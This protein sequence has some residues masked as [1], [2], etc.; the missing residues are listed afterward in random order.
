MGKE[1]LIKLESIS[2]VFSLDQAQNIVVLSEVSLD[3]EQGEFVTIIGSS[4]SGKTTLLNIL[5]MLDYPTEGL[6]KF[7]GKNI[8]QSSKNTQSELRNKYFGFVFQQFNL[9][10]SLNVFHNVA[11]PLKYAEK[12]NEKKIFATLQQLGLEKRIYHPIKKLSGGEQQRVAIARAIINDPKIIIADEPTGNLDSE[13]GK[14]V[15]D[16]FQS[17]HKSGKTI[18]LVTHNKEIA[19]CGT[20]TLHIKDGKI[21]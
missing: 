18:I 21:V 13:T 2:K 7:E 20:K 6:Y 11:L 4:G 12:N 15:M 19:S 8:D 1:S 14:I 10:P 16:I 5:G 9:I 17:L 3:I